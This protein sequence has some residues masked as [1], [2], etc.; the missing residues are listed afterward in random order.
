MDQK[1]DMLAQSAPLSLT[2]LLINIGVGVFLSLYIMNRS[3][4]Y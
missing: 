4:T 3:A 1:L 2:A